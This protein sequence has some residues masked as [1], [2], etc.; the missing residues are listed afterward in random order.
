MS[1]QAWRLRVV[2]SLASPLASRIYTRA[3]L[4]E[5]AVRYRP[6]LTEATFDSLLA[7]LLTASV[8]LYFEDRIFVNLLAEPEISFLEAWAYI[9]DRGI[10]SM[11][12][13]LNAKNIVEMSKDLITIVVPTERENI[14]L[15]DEAFDSEGNRNFIAYGL[16][17]KYFPPHP[18]Y[19]SIIVPSTPFPWFIPEKAL[20]DWLL[21]AT[22]N[23][24]EKMPPTSIN[25]S[26][27]NIP[28]LYR[29]ADQ[30]EMQEILDQYLNEVYIA[31]MKDDEYSTP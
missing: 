14:L 29:L 4:K 21:V 19:I 20:L 17:K 6:S 23:K 5:L 1:Q 31:S 7:D 28:T 13:V 3:M 10:Y 25:I 9:H 30:M 22:K 2:K 26:L 24:Q 27:L 15:L 8:L 16:P 18:E 12:S 11:Q